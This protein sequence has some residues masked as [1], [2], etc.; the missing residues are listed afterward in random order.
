MHPLETRLRDSEESAVIYWGESNSL[1][2]V[3]SW[4]AV[5]EVL[6]VPASDQPAQQDSL[7][8]DVTGSITLNEEELYRKPIEVSATEYK[9][10]PL[11]VK[12]E[13][14]SNIDWVKAA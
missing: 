2:N 1:V 7:D 11:S 5:G 4:R 10:Q 14:V 6:P 3:E 12:Y 8:V 9:E 13:E